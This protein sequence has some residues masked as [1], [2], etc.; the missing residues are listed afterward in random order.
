MASCDDENVKT[1][2]SDFTVQYL[3]ANTTI[4]QNERHWCQHGER[5]QTN[6]CGQN[7]ESKTCSITK[8]FERRMREASLGWTANGSRINTADYTLNVAYK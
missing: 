3:R 5:M 6:E 4:E 8:I 2:V 1:L 7:K